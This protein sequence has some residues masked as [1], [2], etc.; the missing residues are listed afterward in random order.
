MISVKIFG[1]DLDLYQNTQISY[2]LNNPAF[3]GGDINKFNGSYSLPFSIP[4]TPKNRRI[5]NY[6]DLIENNLNLISDEP[7]HISFDRKPIFSGL[8]TVKTP[9]N[10]RS[11]K[12]V[13]L[14]V[15]Q[16]DFKDLKSKT[17]RDLD[18][19]IHEFDSVD[20]VLAHAKATAQNP[21]SYSH[22]F[23]PIRNPSMTE[24]FEIETISGAPHRYINYYDTDSQEFLNDHNQR[25]AA[26]FCRLDYVIS[27]IAELIGRSIIN[28]FASNDELRSLYFYGDKN[29]YTC[30]LYTSPSP[31]DRG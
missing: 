26:P 7:C 29:I 5:L 17:L 4:L 23:F 20:E 27:K 14:Y 16:D 22:A 2:V 28:E 13:K 3:V 11:K 19:G 24:N 25:S 10:S 9:S 18:L 31:R 30:L 6:P 8:A 21:L 1:Q 15:V 12:S